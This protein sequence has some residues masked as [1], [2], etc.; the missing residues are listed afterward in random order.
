MTSLPVE[1]GRP[2]D[3]KGWRNR[4]TSPLA[5]P[6]SSHLD[7]SLVKKV[8]GNGGLDVGSPEDIGAKDKRKIQKKKRR[9]T[10]A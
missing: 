3:V 5:H 9:K 8:F 7:L 6:P 4:L 10:S 1:V 2:C